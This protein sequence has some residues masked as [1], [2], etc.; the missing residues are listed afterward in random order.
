M[1]V[2]ISIIIKKKKFC[3]NNVTHNAAGFMHFADF[4]AKKGTAKTYK[5]EMNDI[6]KGGG[7]FFK[8][9]IPRLSPEEGLNVQRDD[10]LGDRLISCI[11]LLLFG[12]GIHGLVR[13]RREARRISSKLLPVEIQKEKK[14]INQNLVISSNCTSLLT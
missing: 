1:S 7:G 3:G 14:R 5:I 2:Y 9:Y 13:R 4:R 12:A 6:V 10:I 8:H 11:L